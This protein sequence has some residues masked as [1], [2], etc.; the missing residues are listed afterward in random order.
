MT[1]I[2]SRPADDNNDDSDSDVAEGVA[3]AAAKSH[4]LW[5]TFMDGR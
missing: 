1:G 2:T 3:T 4:D 5:G